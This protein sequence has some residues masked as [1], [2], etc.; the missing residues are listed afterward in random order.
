M[1]TNYPTILYESPNQLRYISQTHSFQVLGAAQNSNLPLDNLLHASAH[2]NVMGMTNTL[3]TVETNLRN[4]KQFQGTLFNNPSLPAYTF[5]ENNTSGM[6]QPATNELAFSTNGTERV[7]VTPLGH[8]GIGTANTIATLHVHG[9]SYA[10]SQNTPT[11]NIGQMTQNNNKFSL[12]SNAGRLITS[13]NTKQ[14]HVIQSDFKIGV[15]TVAPLAFLHV[16]NSGNSNLSG[17]AVYNASTSN[18]QDAP[19]L[20]KT[21]S[22]TSAAYT[23][24]EVGTS[25]WSLGVENNAFKVKSISQFSSS[26]AANTTAIMISSVRN[27]GIGSTLPLS[28]L[29]VGGDVTID[30][31]MKIRKFGGIEA[32]WDLTTNTTGEFLLTSLAQRGVLIQNRLEVSDNVRT[33]KVIVFGANMNATIG[34]VAFEVQDGDSLF[35]ENVDIL[36]LLYAESIAQPSS[37]RRLKTNIKTIPDALEKITSLRGV[38]YDWKVPEAHKQTSGIGFIAQE[39]GDVFPSLLVKGSYTAEESQHILPDR[40]CLSYTITAEF[41]AYLV[42]SIKTLKNR[43]E[44]LEAN[45]T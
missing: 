3:M 30:G 12:T 19:L 8:V 18:L 11:V 42:E 13:Y 44:A 22:T 32:G 23:S 40:N 29:H 2:T 4:K 28:R 25:E 7:R 21:D 16:H 31:I 20:L 45:Q 34:E 10:T 5:Y 39:V 26:S 35:R 15:G 43:I 1:T 9:E 36:G 6:Y 37:D 38:T 27:V 14:L 24:F 33:N 41:Y 17:A